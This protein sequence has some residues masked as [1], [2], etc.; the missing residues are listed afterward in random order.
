[1]VTAV[2]PLD[3]WLKVALMT[4]KCSFDLWLRRLFL[5]DSWFVSLFSFDCE[6]LRKKP[7]V[8]TR[9]L[10]GDLFHWLAYWLLTCQWGVRFKALPMWMLRAMQRNGCSFFFLKA[11]YLVLFVLLGVSKLSG[12]FSERHF[13]NGIQ[14]F[15]LPCFT[16]TSLLL[17]NCQISS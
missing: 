12:Q 16:E 7:E 11:N 15:L 2:A 4:V 14:V 13:K 1:M 8:W 6:A 10:S 3:T 5:W 17:E 9:V